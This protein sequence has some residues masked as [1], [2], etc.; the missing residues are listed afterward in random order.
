MSASCSCHSP[1]V[2]YFLLLNRLRPIKGHCDCVEKFCVI[3]LLITRWGFIIFNSL[4]MIAYSQASV[5]ECNTSTDWHYVDHLHEP[6]LGLNCTQPAEED[7]TYSNVCLVLAELQPLTLI[8]CTPLILIIF[9]WWVLFWLA[10][11]SLYPPKRKA[12]RQ[13]WC[14]RWCIL[15]R[16]CDKVEDG[17]APV[18]F[19]E[20]RGQAQRLAIA[21]ALKHKSWT[22]ST[23]LSQRLA[24]LYSA[25]F[26][27]VSVACSVVLL[28]V[29]TDSGFML[30]LEYRSLTLPQLGSHK[31]CSYCDDRNPHHLPFPSPTARITTSAISQPLG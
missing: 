3:L 13:S 29:Y 10:F 5:H 7:C 6:C 20:L 1:D 12:P 9:I 16:W 11:D 24:I 22:Y 27:L 14:R 18:T 2:E 19:D 26:F 21:K 17:Q 30:P 23:F 28:L 15:L 25:L 8:H 31:Q 4:A